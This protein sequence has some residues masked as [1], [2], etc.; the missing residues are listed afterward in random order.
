MPH[1]QQEPACTIG[2]VDGMLSKVLYTLA[3]LLLVAAGVAAAYFAG[4]FDQGEEAPP[5]PAP[6]VDVV[7][8]E[9]VSAPPA[10]VETGFVRAA[11]RIEVAPEIAGRIVEVGE[12]FELGARVAEGDLLVRLDTAAIETDLAR[13]RADLSSAEAAEAQAT[14]SLMRQQELA[15]EDFASEA[16][17]ER[18]RA[19]AAAASARVEQAEAAMEAARIRLQDA[20]LHAPFHA[21][22]IAEDAS[23]GQLLQVGMPIGTLIGA[24][25]AEVRVGLAEQDFR[26]LRRGGGLVGREVEIET[27]ADGPVTGTIAAFAPVLEGQARIVEIVVE[28]PDPFS[29]ETGLVLNGLVTVRI[30]LSETGRALF[31][32]PSGALQTG[33]RLWRVG[34]DDTLEAVAATIQ[35]RGDEAVF[36]RSDELRPEDRIL[37][38]QVANPLPGL[39]VRVR[40]ET[41]HGDAGTQEGDGT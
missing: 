22:V 6:L 20:R 38:T 8:P 32:L 27:G 19:D 14:A 15:E 10:I 4:R 16:E 11:E 26:R 5:P 41:Q 23:V 2:V 25:V 3:G 18:V 7:R 24:D 34:P 28:V 21:L 31:R 36:V 17:L 1:L 33:E 13:A 37:L 12:S 30:P 9:P 40:A 39:E 29:E 35:E